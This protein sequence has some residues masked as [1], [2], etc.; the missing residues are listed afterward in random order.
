MK[1]YFLQFNSF[2]TFELKFL[3]FFSQISFSKFM[4]LYSFLTLSNLDA[5]LTNFI[6][7]YTM[8]TVNTIDDSDHTPSEE[9]LVDFYDSKIYVRN[10][11]PEQ[12]HRKRVLYC[13]GQHD[14][15][16]EY[17]N[18]MNFHYR[19]WKF[20]TPSKY[21]VPKRRQTVNQEGF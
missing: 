1:H 11:S 16:I 5:K 20:T 7:S 21:V 17:D 14:K 19:R 4:F 12:M 3:K 13:H 18:G 8:E 15:K 9:Y 2:D 10:L 6:P